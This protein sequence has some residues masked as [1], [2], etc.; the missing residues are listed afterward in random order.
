MFVGNA[1]GAKKYKIAGQYLQIAYF[2]S[3]LILIP[4]VIL[5]SITGPV[6]KSLGN[7]EELSNASWKYA[8]LLMCALPGRIVF[9]NLTEYFGAM[10][11][12]KPAVRTS[13][14]GIT[15]NLLVGLPLVLG[16]PF[17]K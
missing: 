2:V 8:L 4:V 5:W 14:I 3:F 6:L 13:A 9:K 11:I 1:I 16:W 15:V 7:D 12:T 10:K 17:N